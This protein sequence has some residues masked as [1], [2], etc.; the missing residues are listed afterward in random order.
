MDPWLFENHPMM[1]PPAP[2]GYVWGLALLYAV[3]PGCNFRST[4]PSSI[5]PEGA[6]APVFD[7]LVRVSKGRFEI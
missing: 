2:D 3:T 7:M 1:V 6:A 4:S 5:R